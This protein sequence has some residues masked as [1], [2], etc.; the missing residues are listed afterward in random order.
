[1]MGFVENSALGL[2][3]AINSTVIHSV[4]GTVLMVWYFSCE[5]MDV[6][7]FLPYLDSFCFLFLSS[8]FFWLQFSVT[9]Q[10]TVSQQLPDAHGN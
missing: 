1:M 3:E 4:G 5:A 9:Q 7:F 10:L 8:F 2:L 6:F